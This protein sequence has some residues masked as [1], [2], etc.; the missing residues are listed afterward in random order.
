[1]RKLAIIIL[2]IGALIIVFLV[3]LLVFWR[4]KAVSNDI[5]VPKSFR[6]PTS[7]PFVKGPTSPAPKE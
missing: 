3:G 7:A 6:G 4:P 1:M 2:I 5:A